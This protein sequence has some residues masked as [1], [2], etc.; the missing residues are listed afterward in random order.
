[1]DPLRAGVIQRSVE[2]GKRASELVAPRGAVGDHLLALLL[3][4]GDGS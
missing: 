3:V 2:L 1:M 4:I